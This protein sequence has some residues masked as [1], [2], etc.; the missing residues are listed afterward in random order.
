M[1]TTT[2]NPWKEFEAFTRD[3]HRVF[4]GP[5]SS[6]EH[7]NNG[8]QHAWRPAMD[9]S[10][11]EEA[12]IIEADVPGMDPAD[13]NVQ[14]EG[15]TLILSGTRR[16]TAPQG[17]RV[18]HAER[19]FGTFQ[20]TFTLPNA[21]HAEAIQAAYSNGVVTITVPKAHAARARRINVQTV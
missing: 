15:T 9:V 6:A 4:E 3:L 17:G 12:Y 8:Q 5:A 7:Q 11:T 2:W 21:V 20:R 14:L 1:T 16:S 19:T 10:D 13:I 18:A